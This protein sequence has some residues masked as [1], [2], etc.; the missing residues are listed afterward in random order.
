MSVQAEPKKHQGEVESQLDEMVKW[1]K[2]I[3]MILGD[4]KDVNPEDI[5]EDL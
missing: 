2:V 5:Y 1:L 4:M 3:A